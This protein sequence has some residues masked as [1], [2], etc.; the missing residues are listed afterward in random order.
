M[1]GYWFRRVLRS[2]Y[3]QI[4]QGYDL[5]TMIVT[6]NLS[7]YVLKGF[8]KFPHHK[9]NKITEYEKILLDKHNIY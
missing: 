5:K 3:Q 7:T 6:I 9:L 1:S 4:I 8:L 2:R